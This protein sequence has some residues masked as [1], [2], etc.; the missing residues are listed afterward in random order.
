MT[1]RRDQKYG[2]EEID[3]TMGK[4]EGEEVGPTS[5]CVGPDEVTGLTRQRAA[6]GRSPN[7]LARTGA[8]VAVALALGAYG[9][10]VLADDDGSTEDGSPSESVD[11]S[12]VV[13]DAGI[14]AVTVDGQAV[15]GGATA[16]GGVATAVAPFDAGDGLTPLSE[17]PTWGEASDHNGFSCDASNG[18]GSA[19]AW[20][21][22]VGVLILVAALRRRDHG[23]SVD[24]ER[25]R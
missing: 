6:F 2:T 4:V 23:S 3:N 8:A 9:G 22:S 15:E 11:D 10:P 1:R 16:D 14:V 24:C 19:S 5:A 21:C 18:Q 25:L 17:L 13:Q 12:G 7:G 20:S